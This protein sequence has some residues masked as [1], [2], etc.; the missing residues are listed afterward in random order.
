MCV[1]LR[2]T[3]VLA[4]FLAC[5]VFNRCQ[6][7]PRVSLTEATMH[8]RRRKYYFLINTIKKITLTTT[9]RERERER[10]RERGRAV[11]LGIGALGEEIGV[12]PVV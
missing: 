12:E 1:V 7:P 4:K 6:I 8:A 10:E 3:G 5:E 9:L 11:G 2:G